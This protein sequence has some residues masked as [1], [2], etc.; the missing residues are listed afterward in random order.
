MSTPGV[1]SGAIQPYPWGSRE[2]L[3][4]I[5]GVPPTG[6]PQA[7]LW[8]GAHPRAP[9]VLRRSG[10][11]RP[12][13]Q[14]IADDPIG[15]LGPDTAQTFGGELPF[16]LKI[17]AVDQPLSL[18]T[19]P[20]RSQAHAGF[21][22]EEEQGIPLDAEHR[23]YRDRNHKPELICALEPFT[24]LCGLRTPETAAELLDSLE[25]AALD[26]AISFLQ[27][28]EIAPALRWLLEQP[29]ESGT[30][31]ALQVAAACS[32]SGP[33][34]D[35]RHWGVRIGEQ[36]PG[37]IGVA[38]A[39]MLNL[40]RL[41]PGQALFLRAGNLHVYLRGTVVE[42][43]ANSDNVLRGGLTAKNVDVPALLDVVDCR[44]H[45]VLVQAPTGPCFT[46][47][48]PVP[49]FSLTRVELAG[50]RR[51]TPSGPEIVLCASGSAR[52]AGHKISGGGAVWVPAGTGEF[53]MAGTGLMFR[54]ATGG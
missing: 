21:D 46:F 35:E 39:L 13:H 12:L 15:E 37:D 40:V 8:L 7:E 6:E 22:S 32:K 31:I 30:E 43:M 14:V 50:S 10:T 28:G 41:E 3:P 48:A 26:P 49:D 20:T 29:P 36:H 9:S 53:E 5:M 47:E 1:L 51:F 44:P 23:S 18:Q 17:L 25:V 4:Q 42:I 33:F 16:L 2:V 11:N 19:H 45:D 24:A 27:A 34:P 52:V 54:A 38:V